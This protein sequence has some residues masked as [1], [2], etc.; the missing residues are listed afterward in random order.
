MT[1]SCFNPRSPCG[2][3]LFSPKNVVEG[4]GFQSTLPVWGAT[5][6]YDHSYSQGL[7]SIH[8]PRVGSD[9]PF[10]SLRSCLSCFNPRSPCGERRAKDLERLP[11]TE[12]FNPRSP[13]G[14]RPEAWGSGP[15]DPGFNPR[16]PC[17]ERQQ[18]CTDFSFASSAK[19]VFFVIFSKLGA[20]FRGSAEKGGGI[21]FLDW[22]EPPGG[23]MGT[24]RSRS[25]NQ[26][27]F[28]RI[29]GFTAKVFYFL[30]VLIAKVVES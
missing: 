24:W 29:G 14:E 1:R 3:R 15:T 6:R 9:L 25:E 12:S 7:V 8:A 23:N 20:I 17:G 27:V 5:V 16:S 11:E 19:R 13:C 28:G 2:E 26:G 21:S 22:C 4:Q 30:F 18:R 10:R